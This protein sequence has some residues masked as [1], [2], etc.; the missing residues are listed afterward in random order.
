MAP[1]LGQAL[2][3]RGQVGSQGAQ[4]SRCH[5]SRCLGTGLGTPDLRR[6]RESAPCSEPRTGCIPAATPL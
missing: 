4:W 3:S 1:S 5:T 6:W 2:Q